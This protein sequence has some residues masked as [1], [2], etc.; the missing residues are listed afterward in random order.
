MV[1]YEDLTP[2]PV[3]LPKRR[4]DNLYVRPPMHDQ[5]FVPNVLP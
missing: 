4:D 2:E 3:V 5:T 1:P